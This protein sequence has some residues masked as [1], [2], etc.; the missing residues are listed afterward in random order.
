MLAD[1]DRTGTARLAAAAIPAATPTGRPLLPRRAARRRT[2][3]GRAACR[4]FLDREGACGPTVQRSV[5]QLRGIPRVARAAGPSE[6]PLF[7]AF[8]DRSR[9]QAV[10]TGA[11]CASTRQRRRRGGAPRLLA[12]AAAHAGRDRGH[13]PD[14]AAG[15]RARVSPLRVEVRRAERRVTPGRRAVG[16]TFE[17]VFRQAI[18]YK[19]RNRDTAWYSFSTK[20]GRRSTLPSASGSTPVTSMPTVGS[21]AVS[22]DP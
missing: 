8:V 6:D 10:G 21:A 20:N 14:D 3:C 12:A 13:V 7:F 1:N 16:F 11:Y 17:G 15:V 19:G 2:P 22:G 5:R 9:E 4:E 18:V